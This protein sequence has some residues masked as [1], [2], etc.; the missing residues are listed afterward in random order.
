MADVQTAEQRLGQTLAECVVEVK[1]LKANSE[2]SQAEINNTIEKMSEQIGK[3]DRDLASAKAAA[4]AAPVITGGD[5]VV[6]FGRGAE[7]RGFGRVREVAAGSSRVKVF[8]DGFFTC[9]ET[10]NEDHAKAKAAFELA[11]ARAAAV[12]GY[13]IR[14]TDT[15]LLLVN[16]AQVNRAL[17]EV[18]PDLVGYM[19]VLAHRCGLA[20]SPDQVIERVFGVS[21]GNGS[22]F[23]PAEVL[24]PE[25]TRIAGAAMSDGLPGLFVQRNLTAKNPYM[26]IT[27]ALPRPY[28]KGA[29]TPTSVSEI[30]LSNSTTGKVPM[31]VKGLACGVRIDRDFEDDAILSAMVEVRTDLARS[32]A[33]GLADGLINGD[34]NATHQDTALASWNPEG[35]FALSGAG[36]S[37]DHRKMFLGLRAT[38]FDISNTINVGGDP[39]F[40]TIQAMQGSF[41]GGRGYNPNRCLIVTD[42]ATIVNKLSTISEVTTM[43]KYGNLATA[44]TG[45]LA[46]IGGKPIIRSPFMGRHGTNTGSFTSAGLY[47]TGGTYNKAAIIMVDAD[48]YVVG[49]RKGV[50]IESAPEVGTD[51]N[52][53]IATQR[54]AFQSPDYASAPTSGSTKNVCLAINVNV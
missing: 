16:R 24:F 43:E 34:T 6:R 38:A 52:L 36:G 28:N 9:A 8:E 1:S 15:G 50:T 12:R 11:N 35:V 23:I 3:L 54:V 48:A 14:E 51:T 49:S 4:I 30:L 25:M 5:L 18:A 19:A 13:S 46:K 45:E 44:V 31:T 27:S 37:L 47:T 2:K 22:D 20:D 42:F 29:A 26:M 7:F 17:T 32:M 41:N 40:A 33:L 10:L 53:V 21:S 39:T